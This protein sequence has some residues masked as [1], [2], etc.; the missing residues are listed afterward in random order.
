MSK[1]V[2]PDEVMTEIIDDVSFYTDKNNY[3]DVYVEF[4]TINGGG[5]FGRKDSKYFLAVL[6]HEYRARTGL[7]VNP[8]FETLVDIKGQDA[9]ASQA[10]PVTIYHRLAGKLD[11]TV[12]YYLG[13]KNRQCVVIRPGVWK[14]TPITKSKSKKIKFLQTNVVLPQTMPVAGGN[15]FDLLRPY[16]NL[17]DDDFKLLAICIAQFFSRQRSHFA[18][19][20]SSDKGT[21]KSTL[22][23]L[24]QKLIDPSKIEANV[25]T[26]REQDLKVHLAGSYL[27]CFDNTDYLKT[28]VSNL[29]CSAITGSTVVKRKLYTD[30]DQ[31]VLNLHNAVIL[32]GIGCVPRKSDLIER[33]LLFELQPIGKDNRRTERAFWTDFEKDKPKILGAIFDT[34]S[35][36]MEIL[37]T[38]QVENLHRMADAHEEMLAIALAQGISEEEFTRIFQ[39]N[40]DRLQDA[41]TQNNSF[42]EHVLNYMSK[43]P[44]GIKAPVSKV[45]Q[46]MRDSIVGSADF[47]PKTPNKLSQRLN[48]EKDAL[49]K[50]GYILERGRLNSYA[51]YIRIAP[52]PK[53]QQTKSQK[54]AIKDRTE[55]QVSAPNEK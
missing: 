28:E 14:V 15:Y 54:Q 50:A 11:K 4:N 44:S 8:D 18:L 9:I 41:Y 51:N 52:V 31:V 35:K 47:F 36:A 1:N 32:N 37:P 2:E 20:L 53:N 26:C 25:M 34:L 38:L 42:V 33:S 16:I 13:D 43:R 12:V 24:I 3:E 39:S 5:Y 23:K 17:P 49:L 27:A 48:E 40:L 55:A 22:T 45:F 7:L 29:L 6:G 10:F 30:A 19:I 21:G 46:E